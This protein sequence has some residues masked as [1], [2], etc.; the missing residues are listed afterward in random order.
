MV[1][2][3]LRG[4]IKAKTTFLLREK[5]KEKRREFIK[6]IKIFLEEI[7]ILQMRSHLF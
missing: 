3:I 1:K 7:F 2:K 5:D 6:I 4:L